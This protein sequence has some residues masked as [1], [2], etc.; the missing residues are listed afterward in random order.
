[1]L[2]EFDG[3]TLYW[4]PYPPVEL[5]EMYGPTHIWYF[6]YFKRSFVRRE[7]G[8]FIGY[9]SID[10]YP[11]VY[12]LTYSIA[13]AYVQPHSFN[14]QREIDILCTLRGSKLMT[15]RQ[16]VSDWVALYGQTRNV[17]N[18]VTKQLSTATRTQIDR[19]YFERM[20]NTKI[21]VTVNPAGWEGDFRLW[22]ALATGALIF[23]DPLNVLHPFPLID[24]EHIVYFSNRNRTELFEK[25]DFYRSR[26][27]EAR[28]VA[29][30][31]YLHAMK[32]H[33]TVS[34]VDYVLR[35]VHVK[36]REQEL[37]RRKLANES[38]DDLEK[39]PEYRYTA[40]ELNRQGRVIQR[41]MREQERLEKERLRIEAAQSGLLHFG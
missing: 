34:M 41:F 32:Y 26:P 29:V 40:Q 4:P 15:T 19:M 11:D 36:R 22:E 37:L 25:L 1:V 17:Q 6:M 2:D 7:D 23:V 31:G 35:S 39:L 5:T 10:T 24:G 33:R 30:N 12:P 8:R 21:I 14:V 27:E 3:G 9:P 13:E 28:R 16:R 20:Y 18:I 38:I